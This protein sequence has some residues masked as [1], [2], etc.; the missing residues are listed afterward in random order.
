MGGGI[1]LLGDFAL[2][3]SL[4]SNLAEMA[5]LLIA[6]DRMRE[7]AA[8]TLLGEAFE[9]FA[10]RV[11]SEMKGEQ[12]A[13]CERFVRLYG[14]RPVDTPANATPIATLVHKATDERRVLTIEYV[15][16]GEHRAKR[17]DIEPLGVWLE[18]ARS[19]VVGRDRGKNALRTFAVDRIRGASL[20]EIKFAPPD[21]FD[22]QKPFSWRA[23]RVH[24]RRPGRCGASTRSRSCA[25]AWWKVA[26]QNCEARQATRRRRS[27]AL[28]GTAFRRA[29]RLD[30]H[31]RR[32]RLS[33][34]TDQRR[35]LCPRR[36]CGASQS[37]RHATKHRTTCT[38]ACKKTNRVAWA[39]G[40]TNDE[41]L[42]TR[43]DCTDSDQR[44]LASFLVVPLLAGFF[45]LPPAT[46]PD[47]PID[48]YRSYEHVTCDSDFLGDKFNR[49]PR[50]LRAWQSQR[51]PATCPQ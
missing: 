10:A 8:D 3:V 5:A 39:A 42:V 37:A 22:I 44:R 38:Q 2:R 34:F 51:M 16:P 12:R 50:Q 43:G 41:T 36:F 19:Y 24:W 18:N 33:D 7:L 49:P 48:H 29:S 40:E 20:T 21:G 4:P 31:A 1:R 47:A 30:R 35:D 14:T 45:A 23:R 26:E 13:L 11:L 28:V 27:A 32:G 6:R 25:S 9:Q 17:R 46:K 15:S